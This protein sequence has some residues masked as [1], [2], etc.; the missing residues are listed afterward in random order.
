[1][2][3]FNL[4]KKQFWA[5]VKKDAEKIIEPEKNLNNSTKISF[6]VRYHI[7]FKRKKEASIYTRDREFKNM[8]CYNSKLYDGEEGNCRICSKLMELDKLYTRAEIEQLTE[9]LGYSVFDNIGG[10]ADENGF[11]NCACCWQP[12]AYVKK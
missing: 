3:L 6:M 4:F 10:T 1:M 12:D 9:K 7:A 5:E 8:P 2:G 11:P